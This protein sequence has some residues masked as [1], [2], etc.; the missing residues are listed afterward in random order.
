MQIVP[1]IVIDQP[2][3]N[4]QGAGALNLGKRLGLSINIDNPRASLHNNKVI[5]AVF[6]ESLGTEE[7]Y[8]NDNGDSI[9][10]PSNDSCKSSSP[11]PRG[12][13]VIEDDKILGH[14]QTDEN[15]VFIKYYSIEESIDKMTSSDAKLILSNFKYNAWSGE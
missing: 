7:P 13:A 14:L 2:Q 15:N 3:R 10:S 8:S 5:S 12:D 4:D 1:T 6:D 9:Q 11:K